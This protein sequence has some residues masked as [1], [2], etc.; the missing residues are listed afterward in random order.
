MNVYHFTLKVPSEY[1]KL[2]TFAILCINYICLDVHKSKQKLIIMVK[3]ATIRNKKK[4]VLDFL[5]DLRDNG[6]LYVPIHRLNLDEWF[7]RGV[8]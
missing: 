1:V 4:C 8:F 3:T 6:E 2:W 5:Q 7:K